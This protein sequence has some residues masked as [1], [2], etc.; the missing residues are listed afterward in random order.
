MYRILIPLLWIRDVYRGLRHIRRMRRIEREKRLLDLTSH[1]STLGSMGANNNLSRQRF[2]PEPE[3]EQPPPYSLR[4]IDNWAVAEVGDWV[5]PM[6]NPDFPF[7]DRGLLPS[8]FGDRLYKVLH[9]HENLVEVR[10]SMRDTLML[11]NGQYGVYKPGRDN[12]STSYGF[13]PLER[14]EAKH[15]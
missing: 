3:F 2:G 10:L 4:D 12:Y 9:C 5:L 15:A 8:P 7:R 1:E 13:I 6:L 11:R 14:E